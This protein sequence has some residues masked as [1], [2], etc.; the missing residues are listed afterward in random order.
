MPAYFVKSNQHPFTPS[1]SLRWSIRENLRGWWI[2][3]DESCQY[4]LPGE[5]QLDWSK[6]AG[7]SFHLLKDRKSVV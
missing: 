1:V 2:T 7:L 4:Q 3:L 6:L 5:D